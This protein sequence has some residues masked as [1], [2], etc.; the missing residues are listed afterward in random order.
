M[1]RITCVSIY[2]L[3]DELELDSATLTAM[4]QSR[5]YSTLVAATHQVELISGRFLMPRS[6]SIPHMVQRPASAELLL[7][8][9]LLELQS[10]TNGDSSPIPLDSLEQVDCGLLYALDGYQFLRDNRGKAQPVVVQGIWGW[11]D[12]WSEAWR[13][14]QDRV[15]GTLT[16]YSTS[17]IPVM[18]ADA[19]DP[20]DGTPRF[21]PGQLLKI[22][23][24]YMALQAVDAEENTLRVLRGQLGTSIATHEVGSAIHIYNPP[25]YL[26]SLI[27]RWAVWLY[28]LP[29]YRQRTSVP[30]DLM[31]EANALRRVSV[32]S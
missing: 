19:S 27:V 17:V 32:K 13:A 3:L 7:D 28:Q 26:E 8:E 12:A 21:Q 24:E 6:L 31:L 18:D 30:A 29:Q 15:D 10:V 9:D 11:H 23:G 22:G 2:R 5:L 16:P 20:V 4:E 14:S 25:P 1:P